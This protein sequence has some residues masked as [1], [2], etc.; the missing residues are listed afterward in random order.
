[1]A[2]LEWKIPDPA[3]AVVQIDSDDDKMITDLARTLDAI[4]AFGQAAQETTQPGI[5]P[6]GRAVTLTE[7]QAGD[8]HNI[9]TDLMHHWHPSSQT[10]D[11]CCEFCCNT[12]NTNHGTVTH[13]DDCDGTKFLKIINDQLEG[14]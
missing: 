13:C 4:V 8:L 11:Y 1:M 6:R 5:G 7:D 14:S 12:A 3:F 2:K 10:S 9:I